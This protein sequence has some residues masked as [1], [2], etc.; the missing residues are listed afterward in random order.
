MRGVKLSDEK[1]SEIL[2]RVKDGEIVVDVAAEY[3]ISPK[4]IYN[5]LSS[6]TTAD[7]SALEMSRL[8]RENKA[9]K[10][11]VGKITYDLSKEKKE[12]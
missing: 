4:T 8:K 3:G 1:W 7:P 9:L 10:E 2:R 11:L 12:L 6:K 5:R